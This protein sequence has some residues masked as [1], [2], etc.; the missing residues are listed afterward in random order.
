MSTDEKKDFFVS[1]NRHDKA[2]AEWIAWILEESGYT[3]VIQAWDFRPGGNFVLDMQRAASEAE[4]TIAVLSE[5]YLSS[6]F[7]QPEWA[8]AFAQDP[9]GE[10]RSLIP[11]R[12]GNCSLVGMWATIVYVDLAEVDET[13]ARD[14]VL[15]A[16]QDGRAKPDRAP[17][18]PGNRQKPVYPPKKESTPEEKLREIRSRLITATSER[19]LRALMYETEAISLKYE[20]VE[21]RLLKDEIQTAIWYYHP[22]MP[23]MSQRPKR[24]VPSGSW[25]SA[26]SRIIAVI[27]LC[28]FSLI[29]ALAMF[30]FGLQKPTIKPSPLPTNQSESKPHSWS[31]SFLLTQSLLQKVLQENRVDE[32]SDDS[33][34]RSILQE[35]QNSLN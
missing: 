24:S 10:K 22:S 12:I 16:V 9:T 35:L 20:L 23:S 11:I 19:Q 21:A 34:T 18:F 25:Q 4:R 27:V 33:M 13:S 32:L 3:V 1:Y 31:L 26:R 29:A 14:L 2:W 15:Q 5:N 17:Q 6:Q 7:T 30:F 28:L 8:S